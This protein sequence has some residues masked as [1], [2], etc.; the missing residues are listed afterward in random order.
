MAKKS[1]KKR[2]ELVQAVNDEIDII[3]VKDPELARTVLRIK[4][5]GTVA[6]IVAI[7]AIATAVGSA[8]ATAGSGGTSVPVTA[9]VGLAA[10]ATATGILGPAALSAIGIAVASGGVAVLNKL[11]GYSAEEAGSDGVILRKA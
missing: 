11:R 6:W 9:P 7:G 10:T 5:T 4:A 1:V 8:I 2:Q 3:Y